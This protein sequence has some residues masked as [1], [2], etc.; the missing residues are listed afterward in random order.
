MSIQKAS[1]TGPEVRTCERIH[2]FSPN[3]HQVPFLP[4]HCSR[5]WGSSRPYPQ[6]AHSLVVV[7]MGEQTR[8]TECEVVISPMKENRL[9]KCIE[10]DGLV[11]LLVSR[12]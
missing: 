2:S 1:C 8:N 6:E 7:V 11:V 3:R 12:S 9:D 4:R 10:S 5:P